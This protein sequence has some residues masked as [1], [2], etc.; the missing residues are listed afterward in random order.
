MDFTK[1]AAGVDDESGVPQT[2][3]MDRILASHFQTA[4]GANYAGSCSSQPEGCKGVYQGQLQPY[5]IYVPTK[6]PPATG[7][8]LTLL[9][10]ALDS[11]YN[12]FEGSRNQSQFGQRGT[13][14]IV[15]TPEA[16]GP[17]GSYTSY[18]E[19][20]VFEAWA[21]VAAHYHLNPEISDVTGYSMGAIGTFKLAEQFPDLFARA[22]STS[23]ADF[24]GGLASLRNVPVLMWSTAA[25]EEVLASEYL[26]T[27]NTL[28]HLGYRYELD[29]F[30]PGEHNSFAVLD[31]YAPA[32]AF[33]GDATVDRDPADVTFAVNPTHDYPALGLLT[34]HAYWL[35][36]LTP[37]GGSGSTGTINA[38]SH[39][40]GVANAPASGLQTGTGTLTD[41]NVLPF[42]AYDRSFQTWGATPAARTADQLDIT[43]TNVATVTIDAARA[44]V[45][46]AAKL[47]VVSNVPLKINLAGCG[48]T[49]TI[50]VRPGCPGATGGLNGVSL[51]SARL[52]L[53]RARVRRAFR[54]SSNRGRRYMD[55]F[56]LTPNGIRAGYPAPKLLRAL[57]PAERRRV[58]GRVVLVL[59]ANPHYALRGVRPG[60]RLEA[61]ARRL[62]IGARFQIGLNTWYLAP[63]G[64]S[65]GVLKVRHGVIEEVGVANRQLTS[66]RRAARRFLAS[67]S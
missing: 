9:M 44:H 50:P 1:L 59:T 43:S 38:F 21:D 62:R 10:H 18:A 55:F 22:F 11:N 26:P 5:A 12:L 16:R 64:P 6:P 65:H 27:A 40:F 30:A 32:A 61:V 35:S 31:Q 66:H 25:D 17:D 8:G 20:D 14:S 15:I 45:D 53:T 41:T 54:R 13:G 23:G 34:D 46:C 4:P 2:G 19:A 58:Q 37:S 29:V 3:A 56:C 7:Y 47:N 51:G 42:V 63:N 52:G 48:G 28:L 67:F 33:L 60:A 49:H 36:G 24:N 39:G 57:S